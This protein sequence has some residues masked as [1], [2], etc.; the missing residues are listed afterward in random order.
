MPPSP[1]R[2]PNWVAP[3]SLLGSY[4]LVL[5]GLELGVDRLRRYDHLSWDILATWDNLAFA[6]ALT[7][8][9]L[10]P[11]W[12]GAVV[13]RF[14]RWVAVAVTA[15]V[16]LLTEVHLLLLFYR[17]RTGNSLDFFFFWY[18][19]NDAL[20]TVVKAVGFWPIALALA[21]LPLVAGFWWVHLSRLRRALIA[22]PRRRWITA[23]LGV[24]LIFNLT[25]VVAAP[26]T[27]GGELVKFIPRRGMS[28]RSRY[29]RDYLDHLD[30]V[31]AARGQLLPQA[32]AELGEHLFF[33]H[34]ESVSGPLVD[35]TITP[36]LVAAASDGGVRFTRHYAN[37]VQT[38]RVQESILCGLP[39]SL[40]STVVQNLTPTQLREL[41]CLPRLLSGLGY[42]TMFFKDHRLNFAATDTFMAGIGFD[43]VHADDLMQPGDPQTEWGYREDVFFRRVFGYLERYRGQRTFAYIVLSATNHYPFFSRRIPAAPIA[44]LPY[45]QPTTFRDVLANS[46]YRQDAYLGEMLRGV[47]ES[48][49]PDSSWLIFGDNAWPLG[50]HPGNTFNE[51]NA[52]EENFLTTLV[53]LPPTASR[54]RFAMGRL[55]A[56]PSSHMDI[57]PTLVEFGGGQPGPLLGQSFAGQLRAASPPPSAVHPVLAIQPYGGTQIVQIEYPRKYRLDLATDRLVTFDLAVDPGERTPIADQPIGL[58]LPVLDRLL[59]PS[60]V[61]AAGD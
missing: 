20:D 58:A 4:W 11:L 2:L 3:V 29:T 54:G 16:A 32:P 19:R 34:L 27:Y 40:G 12:L 17:L 57:M 43:E 28:V 18:N 9:L 30:R 48:W 44:G 61:V 42:R 56:T 52:H 5:V 8:L 38:I 60:P 7:Y 21:P 41:P 51:F 26:A 25:A 59:T 13:A 53:F 49:R 6:L 36:Q 39:P 22:H 10:L 35:A 55:V 47:G 23:G 14:R 50:E 31:R 15:G 33:I 24:A 37:S 46:T 1:P 45:P